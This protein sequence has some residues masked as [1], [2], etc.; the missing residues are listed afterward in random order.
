M[1]MLRRILLPVGAVFALFFSALWLLSWMNPQ[2]VTKS[3]VTFVRAQVEAEVR[4]RAAAYDDAFLAGKA[5]RLLEAYGGEIAAAK[6]YLSDNL[7]A[8]IETVVAQVQSGTMPAA[9]PEAAD[10]RFSVLT[11]MTNK[12]RALVY[13]KY[14]S[15]TGKLLREFRIFTGMNAAIFIVFSV[16]MGV[17]RDKVKALL[18]PAFLMLPTVALTGYFYLFGQN[19]LHTLLYNHYVGYACLAWNGVIFLF[20]VDIFINKARVTEC[21]VGM[22]KECVSGLLPG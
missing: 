16:M 7:S 10:G 19:W 5:Q 4:E 12:L 21:I 11:R 8:Q 17:R 13:E 22:L 14:V 3:A 20:L 18:V 6:R 9:E 2:W 1:F 15:V